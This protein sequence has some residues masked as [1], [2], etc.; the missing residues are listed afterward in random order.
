M[1]VGQALSQPLM[2]VGKDLLIATGGIVFLSLIILALTNFY[3]ILNPRMT[4]QVKSGLV[5]VILSC[6]LLAA[7]GVG[8]VALGAVAARGAA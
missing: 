8:S 3:S 1:G 2:D 6:A 4:D 5:K 7:A